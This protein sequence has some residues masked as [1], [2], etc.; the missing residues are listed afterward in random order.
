MVMG[1]VFSV[2]D[3]GVKSKVFLVLFDCEENEFSDKPVAAEVLVQIDG[4]SI[5]F[6][7]GSAA[8][9]MKGN[10]INGI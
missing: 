2:R 7:S 3:D 9:K 8:L 6:D 10:G 4:R 1:L 5:G